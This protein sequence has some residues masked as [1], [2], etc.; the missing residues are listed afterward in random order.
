MPSKDALEEGEL[1]SKRPRLPKGRPPPEE[2]WAPCIRLV[3]LES[4][5]MA[6]GTVHIVTQKGAKI[7]RWAINRIGYGLRLWEVW[8][9]K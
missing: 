4:E 2:D 3:V 9:E 5:K 6:V 1:P 7:G 8:R